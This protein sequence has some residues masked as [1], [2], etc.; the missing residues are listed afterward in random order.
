MS[1]QKT[2]KEIQ[3]KID[4]LTE[5]LAATL[6]LEIADLQLSKLIKEKPNIRLF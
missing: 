4:A 6:R 3:A 5:Q 1:D 2:S